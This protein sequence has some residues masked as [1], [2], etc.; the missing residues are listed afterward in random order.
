V[1]YYKQTLTHTYSGNGPYSAYWSTCCWISGISNR[2]GGWNHKITVYPLYNGPVFNSPAFFTTCSNAPFIQNLNGADPERGTIT[3]TLRNAPS[4]MT[5][6][7]SGELRWPS[8]KSSPRYHVFEV[9][10]TSS[11]SKATAYREIMVTVSGTC[12]N[13]TPT[14]TLSKTSATVK[15]GQRVC[16]TVTGSDPD[17]NSIQFIVTPKKSG[18]TNPPSGYKSSPHTWTWCWTPT[19]A[20]EG[21]RHDILFTV[22]DN[23]RPA[24]NAQKRFLITVAS[25]VPPTISISPTGTSKSVN[26]GSTLTFTATAAD[27]DG[28]GIASFTTS[29]RPSFCTQSPSSSTSKYTITC[30]PG[31]GNSGTYRITFTAK[32]RDGK[33]KTT[34][35]TVTITVKNVNRTPTISGIASSYTINEGQ[36]LTFSGTAADPDGNLST[37][38]FSCSRPSGSSC[39]LGGS[40]NSSRSVS[41]S[42]TPGYTQAG[43]YTV[44]ISIK[45]SGGLT[46]TKTVTITVNNVNRA[47]TLSGFSTSYSVNEN[48]T[49]SFRVTGTDPDGNLSSLTHSTKPS[50]SSITSSGSGNTRYLNFSWRPTYSQAGTY[51]VTFTARDSNNLTKSTTVTITVRDVNRAPTLSNPGNKTVNEGSMLTFSISAS[52]PDGDTISWLT[53]TGVP[54]GASITGTGNSR[55]FTWRPNNSQSGRY[56]VKFSIRDAKGATASRTITIT[57][58]NVNRAPVFTTK[59]KAAY[60]INEA[61]RISFGIAASDPDGN[62]LTWSTSG[63]PSGSTFTGS[64]TSRT[65][66]WT[67]SYTQAGTYKITFTVKDNGSPN[68]S[69][70]YVVTITVNNVN[71]RPSISNPGNRSINEGSLLSFT[72]TGSDPDGNALTFTTT[73]LPTGATYTGSGNV[74]TFSWRPSYSQAGSYKVTFTVTDNGSPKLAAS[75]TITISVTNINRR[76][77]LTNPGDKSIAENTPLSFSI[78]GADADGNTLTW[79]Y[80]GVP[81]GA[82]ITGSGN[83]KTFSWTPAF[84]QSG[85]Y[86]VVFTVTDNGSPNLAASR[87]IRINVSNKNRAPILTNPGSKSVVE[88]KALSFT[89][90]GSDPDGNALTWSYSGVPTGAKITGSGNTK[91]FSWTPSYT[92]AGTYRVTFNI[93]DNGSPVLNAARTVVISVGNINRTPTLTNPG[94]SF[95]T[96]E[97]K[98]VSFNI[99]GADP[100]GNKLTWSI[101][102][103]PTG[104]RISGSGNTKTFSWTPSYTQAGKYTV[105]FRV[106]DDGSPKL[107]ATRTV[108]ITVSNVNR[109]PSLK[110][111]PAQTVAE[112]KMLTFTMSASDPDGNAITWSFTSVPTGAKITGSGNSRT[113]TWT[114][115][116]FQTGSYKL[117]VSIVDN[118][119]PTKLSASGSV[120]IT[121]ANVNRVPVLTN[122][123]AQSV[124]ENKTLTFTITGSDPDNNALTWKYSGVPTGA[125]ITGS[126]NTKTFTWKPTFKQSGRFN[127]TFTVTD[128]DAKPLSASRTVAITVQ[129]IN[130]APSLTAP[131]PYTI[132]EVQK[133]SFTITGSDPDGNALTWKITGVPTGAK[134]TT[135]GNSRIF[136]WTPGYEQA[137][138]YTVTFEIVDDGTPPL[139]AKRSVSITVTNVNR[140]PRFTS[141]PPPTAIEDRLYSY[142]ATATDPDLK[143][144]LT[145]SKISGPNGSAVTSTGIVTWTPKDADA[146]KTFGFEIR[147]CDQL[148]S[149]VNQKWTVKVINVNDPP[150][151]TTKASQTA[152]EDVIYTYSPKFTDPDPG[153]SHT[154]KFLQGPKEMNMD[155]KTGRLFWTPSDVYAG[156]TVTVAIQV[157]DK[158]GAC[159]TENWNIKVSNKNDAPKI[160]SIPPTVALESKTYTYSAKVTDPDPNDSHTWKLL[161]GPSGSR[162]STRGVVTW[163]SKA[164]D[165]NKSYSFEIQVCDK[166]G[167]CDKQ[168]WRVT[169]KNTNNPPKITS[170]PPTTA[171]EGK[172]YSYPAKA[173]DADPGD[174]LTWSLKSGPKTAKM[175]PRTGLLTWTPGDEDVTAT[176][177]FEIEVCDSAAACDTQR[178]TVR[179]INVNDAPKITTTPF[180]AIS[181]K[182]LYRYQALATDPDPG[183]VLTWSYVKAP[184]GAKIDSSQGIVTWQPGTGD[185]GKTYDFEIKVC[186]K[187]KACDVQK[188]TVRVTNV[189]D[190]PVI[191]ST[192]VSSATENQS[193]IYNA[194]ATDPDPND[195]LSWKLV[196]GPQGA[197]MDTK[198]GKLTWKPTDQD[199]GKD[200]DFVI[201]VC[202]SAGDCDTQTWKV[203]VTNVND[204]PKITSTPNNYATEGRLYGYSPTFTDSD[205]NDTHTWRLLKGPKGTKIDAKTGE[206]EW[207]PGTG[208]A[209]KTFDFEIEI[210]DK[211]RDCDTQKWTVTVRNTNDGPTITSKAPTSAE[212]GKAYSYSPTAT[213]P[214]PND[215]LTWRGKELPPGAKMDTKTGKITW[216][217]KKEDADKTFDFEIEVCDKAGLCDTQK[218]QIT[219]GN[220]NDAPVISGTPGD[221]AY[222][223][224]KYSYQ[225]KVTD[226][227]PNDTHSWGFKKAPAGAV[228]DR[229]TGEITW[230]AVSGDTGNTYDITVEVCDSGKPVKCATQSFKVTVY[231]ACSTD[232]N[233]SDDQL[234]QQG[235]CVE[236]EC[237]SKKPCPNKGD[238]CINGKCKQ[239][240]CKTIQCATDEICRPTDGKCI[241]PCAGVTC[242]NGQFCKDGKCVA[243][244]C[245]ATPCKAG[246]VCDSTTDPANPTCVKNPCDAVT[247]KNGRVCNQQGQC[248]DDPCKRMKCPD[249]TSQQCVAGQCV[250]RKACKV[251]S[252]CP[253]AQICLN[254]RCNDPNCYDTKGT[255]ACTKGEYC[256]SAKCTADPCK[257][258]NGLNK[259]AGGE[260]C[261]RS[262]G[263]CAKPCDKVQCKAGEQCVDGACAKDPCANIQCAVGE[264]CVAGTCEEEKCKNTS[265]CKYGR[266]CNTVTNRCGDDPC[267][268]V[269]CPDS[270]QVCKNGQCQAP[271]VCTVDKDCP[272]DKLCDRGKCVSPDCTADGDCKAD[273][274]CVGGRCKVDSCKVQTCDKGKFCRAGKCVDSCAGVY[275]ARGEKCV[276]GRCVADACADVTCNNG[277]T[278][279]N[280]TCVKDKCD[281]FTCKAGRVCK[282]DRCVEDPC[283]GVTCPDG[284]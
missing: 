105:T 11:K 194:T 66:T 193:Y 269:K 192:P 132:K 148:K 67:P 79:K 166:A 29:G 27:P 110:L 165:A 90:S 102:G 177:T 12:N 218:W 183:D 244:P 136:T 214:D 191:T 173:T 253:G 233:C 180:T 117:G 168:A 48:S 171:T 94:T 156:Q 201:E 160:T 122:P 219:V 238:L 149:C 103:S 62:A 2:S 13:K 85:T 235:L 264:V 251:D 24:L 187:A 215:V 274:I 89:I 116:Y 87:T 127:V 143:T 47:P 147:V 206:I 216:T 130:L 73:G 69:V 56:N 250:D 96:V 262:D 49:L 155:P 120:T 40:G 35:T 86:N 157:C 153:D 150:V 223:G 44:K 88:G 59:P 14:I 126:G 261:R 68:L 101:T 92:Q 259:C 20:D 196:K 36:R 208:D 151:I 61:Q 152:T 174:T 217:P 50:G 37:G 74:R 38:T 109:R 3:Y 255:N 252:D 275:C 112:G 200:V 221:K 65:F 197:T 242:S 131:G 185:A 30:R 60:T 25:G 84:N 83:T 167:A 71:R 19:K 76:P 175:D 81:T 249:P 226:A 52:D 63:A 243:D 18:A 144:T 220:I 280:G 123:G 188:W 263:Q 53:T 202:D 232:S 236:A 237:T 115:T 119:T 46:A 224:R 282:G 234:C 225:P 277:E 176:H 54:S 265:A 229:K 7:S 31:Y 284:Q 82:K 5:L 9:V 164:S 15:G 42:W 181:E 45:D 211:D 240:P 163:T 28:N 106:T 124:A 16:T 111:P 199:A 186:D 23:G 134:V 222:V 55:T 133:L 8:P 204:A 142:R 32:D 141:K 227:D 135:S 162:I 257:D 34:S 98:A 254:D 10:I 75:R 247:C 128:N 17:R 1:R 178:W 268:G 195:V 203:T 260:F 189:N 278:C 100:D 248:V 281:T 283:T 104:A 77:T 97:N 70:S 99:T 41:F 64:S 145:F 266:F 273:E 80:S 239:D 245:A 230:T 169:V 267:A 140:P 93:R 158:A 209:G 138:S 91:T 39:S 172:L 256:L 231:Q 58:N 207:T 246:E 146:E 43:R 6:N 125:K 279:V 198:T 72:V 33:P 22:Q 258:S 205:N 137:G 182:R 95:S 118:G 108:T 170:T 57:V 241:Q 228:I 272:N 184:R 159:D 139:G 107:S 161:K 21:T 210:C 51:R 213:D 113:F 4:G 154:W 78:T 276:D 121:V 26:E 212:E 114:P 271:D 129:N 190:G 179:V 270:K